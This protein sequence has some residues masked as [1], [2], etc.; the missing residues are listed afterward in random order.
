MSSCTGRLSI[1][2][3]VI[4]AAST[5]F[6]RFSI[7]SKVHTSPTGT[8]CRAVTTPVQPACLISHKLTGSLGPYQRMV[9]SINI[10]YRFNFCNVLLCYN[11]LRIVDTLANCNSR[12]ILK[13]MALHQCNLPSTSKLLYGQ[14]KQFSFCFLYA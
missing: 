10:S 7:S 8:W 14:F 4:P 13:S 12:D 9:C 1:T 6:L 11:H 5:S 2:V 3:Q